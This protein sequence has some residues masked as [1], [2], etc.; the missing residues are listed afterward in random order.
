MTIRRKNIYQVPIPNFLLQNG[1]NK[2][3]SPLQYYKLLLELQH[4]FQKQ[5]IGKKTI[6]QLLNLIQDLT[7]YYQILSLYFEQQQ[8]SAK[9]I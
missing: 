7:S 4:I 6:C 1:Y 8:L 3:D 2:L 5:D 9:T